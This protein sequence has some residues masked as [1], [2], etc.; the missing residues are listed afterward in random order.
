MFKRLP[1]LL[2]IGCIFALVA[3]GGASA[4]DIPP[5]SPATDPSYKQRVINIIRQIDTGLSTPSGTNPIT[6][7]AY[8]ATEV[9][10]GLTTAR[11][12]AGTLPRLSAFTGRI[13][14]LVLGGTAGYLGW[15]IGTPLGGYVYKKI[16][17]DD[18][19]STDYGGTAVY[20]VYVSAAVGIAGFSYNCSA[21]GGCFEL[22]G[23]ANGGPYYCIPYNVSGCTVTQ[24]QK[25][26]TSLQ[27]MTDS[28]EILNTSSASSSCGTATIGACGI[29]IRTVQQMAKR[30]KVVASNATE[31]G[32]A[33]TNY[34]Q[35]NEDW[36]IPTSTTDADYEAFLEALKAFDGVDSHR[37]ASQQAALQAVNVT[38][39]PSWT[40]GD[41]IPDPGQAPTPVTG[42]S[43][44]SFSLSLPEPLQNE[45]Y[46]QYIERLRAAGAVGTITV[47][48]DSTTYPG[49]SPAA[50]APDGTV[51]RVTVGT[52]VARRYNATTGELEWP[53]N[54][55]IINA[56]DTAI[57]LHAIPG[58][59]ADG[60]GGIDFSPISDLDP[61]CKFPYGFICYAQ[62]VN[63]WFDVTPTAPRFDLPVHGLTASGSTVTLGNHYDV[64]LNV[65][66][67]Y[68]EIWRSLLSVVIWIGAVYI[69]ATRLLGFKAGGDP[70]EAMDD[71]L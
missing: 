48:T 70:G 43:G 51:T 23:G 28:Q 22:S 30:L 56:A 36:N 52:D 15:K 38:L 37:T 12:A 41:P 59:P 24:S 7:S 46:P 53:N 62:D 19:S 45:T 18:Y 4:T 17:G 1:H 49:G 13:P 34:K 55:P 32:N 65:M 35:N 40:P 47:S 57:T 69:L 71:V 20:W 11:S 8:T 29:R 14:L 31:Y 27:A 58:T 66:D 10:T 25:W 2:L 50:L 26:T 63:A 68:M 6:G 42:A 3:A 39:A 61:G 5:L 67:D 21:T 16:T 64:N 33:A 9:E 60:I 44:S 54:S